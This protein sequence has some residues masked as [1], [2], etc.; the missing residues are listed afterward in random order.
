MKVKN[1]V[2]HVRRNLLLGIP[3]F[4]MG[5]SAVP[6]ATFAHAIA[7]A[8]P[9]AERAISHAAFRQA[10]EAM[11]DE[12][13]KITR[14]ALARD[15]VNEAFAWQGE[16]PQSALFRAM[17][18]PILPAHLDETKYDVTD[19]RRR[20]PVQI[21]AAGPANG[22]PQARTCDW[23]ARQGARPPVQAGRVS[24]RT[25]RQLLLLERG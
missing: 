12:T 18:I 5:T 21:G 22:P 24:G 1:R 3:A 13:I 19:L 15:A 14:R 11:L 20:Y 2:D 10:K 16:F 4:A 8:V 9:D 7:D 23:L 6:R 25:L 17:E